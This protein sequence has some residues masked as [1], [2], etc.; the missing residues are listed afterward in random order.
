M[1]SCSRCGTK[2]PVGARFCA[3]CGAP[4][5][6]QPAVAERKLATILFADLVGS[7]A[8]AA[9]ADPERTRVVLER[10][11]DAMAEEVTLAGGTIEKFAGDAVMAAFG[12]PAALEDHAERALHAGLAMQRRLAELFGGD[13]ALRV[14]VNTGEVVVGG[15]REGSSF[16][17]GDAVNVAARLEQAAGPGEILVGERTAA[18]VRGAFE[19]DASQ[20]VEAKGKPGGVEARRLVRAL[21]LMRPRGG[22][23]LG[24]AFVGR[25]RE[26]ELLE[27]TYRRAV[28]HG[29]PHLVTIIGDT[30]VGKTRLVRELWQRFAG[31]SPEPFRR[32]G[33]CLPYGQ[34]ITYWP[35][36]EILKEHLGILERD[37]PEQM[38]ARLGEHEALALALGLAPP[39][40]LHPLE[41]RERLH[42]TWVEF[43]DEL[44]RERPTVLLLEDLH[45]ADDEL[46]ELAE[47]IVREVAGP[48]VVLAVARPELLDRRPS[49]GSRLRNATVL[50]LEP[51]S[52]TETERLVEELL[53]RDL[54]REVHTLVVDHAEGNPFFVEELLATLIDRGVLVRQNGGFEVGELAEVEL[55]D[56]VHAVVAARIDLLPPAEKAAL[57]AAAV[58]GRVFW[59]GPIRELAGDD[60]S[61]ELLEE[62]DFIRRRPGSTMPGEREYAIKHAVTREVAYAG[63]PKARRARMHA[64]FAAWLEGVGTRDEHAPLVAHHYAEAVRPED[65]DLAW[66]DAPDELA[67]LRLRAI[68]WLRR[69]GELAVTRYEIDDGLALLQR[70]LTLEEDRSGQVRLWH[71]I[72]RAHALKFDGEPFW[73]AMLRAIELSEDP[74]TSA[75]LYADL[76][77]NTVGRVGM[78]RRLPESALVH[79][80]IER[81][82]E[83]SDPGSKA[84]ATALIA[85]SMWDRADAEEHAPMRAATEAALIAENLGD[86]DLRAAALTA[87]AFAAYTEGRHEDALAWSERAFGL[88]D[89]I[90]DPDLVADVYQTASLPALA[91]GRFRE[92]RRLTQRFDEVNSRLTDHHRV[93]GVAVRVELEELAGEWPSVLAM[94]D[95]VESLIERN[96]DTPCIRNPR[97]LLVAALAHVHA[98]DEQEA[99]RLEARAAEMWMEGFG[100]SLDAP[101]IRLALER[102]DLGLV[103]SLLVESPLR[104][105]TTFGPASHSAWL[106][107]RAALGDRQ[108]LEDD[109]PQ[110]LRPNTYLEPF[111]LRA[112]GVV[113]E[114][115]ALIRQALER[116]EAMGLDWHAGE[117]R[118]ALARG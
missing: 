86:P 46:L 25:E 99:R 66:A 88:I 26:L 2:L 1:P 9:N 103:E 77:H 61:F 8:L 39:A 57:Q 16:V 22:A 24:S 17:S 33:R 81:A 18:A 62:R 117:T 59:T 11:Y 21:S 44:L 12:A 105:Y 113:R 118:N 76:A 114:D 107:A 31:E 97:S 75:Q 87:G 63:L 56:S 36:G 95:R 78:W 101:R 83:L 15:P 116:F 20:S 49:W 58:A 72:G 50:R 43:L 27:A 109:A 104:L 7:T 93:H 90:R 79:G 108:R 35:L 13:L 115:D 42:E 71:A 47:R 29:E 96:L 94:Q 14:G 54:A 45:W 65:A 34:G 3:S 100:M 52:A 69:A 40:G 23:G 112:L 106:D 70:A 64:A 4:V 80:W 51:L 85:A 67:H 41:A 91:R 30:G 98:G 37:T 110:F 6:K 19:L 111:A 73:A 5:E 55:P 48:L 32:T 28:E 82:L 53:S 60:V 84:R 92:G 10:F 89:D 38:H 74:A 68:E 102:G